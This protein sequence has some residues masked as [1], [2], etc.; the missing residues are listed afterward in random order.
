MLI[1]PTLPPTVAEFRAMFPEFSDMSDA[2][3]QLSIDTG[4]LWVD[5]FWSP[6]DAKLGVMYA[7]A[8]YLQMH[9]LAT[10][11]ALGEGESGGSGGEVGPIDPDVGKIWI[12]SVRFRD[13][14]VTYDRVGVAASKQGG[15]GSV[16][17]SAEEFW[18]AT[19]YGQ[20]YLSFLRRNAPHVAVI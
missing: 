2:T 3:V 7:A 20:M 19:P 6:Y 8:H 4:M 13:R 11:G 17:S 18:E 14:Q 9:Q 15:G 5:T 12:K 1:N 10:G 16:T